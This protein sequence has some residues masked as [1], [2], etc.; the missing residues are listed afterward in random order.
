MYP[1]IESQLQPL[2]HACCETLL[3]YK[4]MCRTDTIM[5]GNIL[6]DGDFEV[7]LSK[8]LGAHFKEREK[9]NL[10]NDAHNIAK[11]LIDVMDRRS[12]ELDTGTYP[13]PQPVVSQI[14]HSGVVG[15][16]LENLGKQRLQGIMRYPS[17]ARPL[18]PNDLPDG[19]IAKLSY[20]HR[21]HCIAFTH[22]TLGE[23]GRI[24]LSEVNEETLI[25]A[26]LCTVSAE[27]VG[28]KQKLM[29]E[30]VVMIGVGLTRFPTC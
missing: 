26:E 1:D 14:G 30:I 28:Q 10:F 13:D 7:M 5:D 8:G 22:E 11:L 20:D 23:I 3:R 12:K 29:E 27:H 21:G 15:P 16:G 19:V 25:E 6:M 24:V 2:V 17:G 9:Q 18:T 4:A